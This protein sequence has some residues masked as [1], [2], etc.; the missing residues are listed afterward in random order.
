MRG[1]YW[2]DKGYTQS[3]KI[4]PGYMLDMNTGQRRAVK[5]GEILDF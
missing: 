5:G 2:E 3:G 1:G 4:E